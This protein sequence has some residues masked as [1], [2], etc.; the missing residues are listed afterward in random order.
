MIGVERHATLF[1]RI[2]LGPLLAGGVESTALSQYA[3]H[4][5]CRFA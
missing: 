4:G 1:L 3:L 5:L 2:H